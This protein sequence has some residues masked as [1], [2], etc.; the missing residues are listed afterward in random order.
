[1][2]SHWLQPED[3]KSN[4]KQGFSPKAM[5]GLAKADSPCAFLFLWINPESNSGSMKNLF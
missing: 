2:I 4:N 1:M 3:N 5:A